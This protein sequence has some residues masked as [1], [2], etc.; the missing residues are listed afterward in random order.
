[1]THRL[2]VVLQTAHPRQLADFWRAV[3]GYVPEP[4]PDGFDTWEDFAQHAGID[5][6]SADIDAAID[7]DGRGPRPLFER[8]DEITTGNAVHLDINLTRRGDDLDTARRT[9]DAKAAELLQVGATRHRVVEQDH[10][11]WI[12]LLDPDGNWFCIQ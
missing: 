5:L 9:I 10:P 3:L 6:D 7:P 8:L 4:P 12:E 11:Y 2:Q 1:M